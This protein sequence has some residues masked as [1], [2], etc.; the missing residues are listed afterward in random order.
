MTYGYS[1]QE[2]DST[3]SH[4]PELQDPLIVKEMLSM[5]VKPPAFSS[6]YRVNILHPEHA[7]I[8]EAIQSH[9]QVMYTL[10]PDVEIQSFDHEENAGSTTHIF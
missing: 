5:P 6:I 8:W 1:S 9:R 2:V 4:W 3:L 7:R 10:S